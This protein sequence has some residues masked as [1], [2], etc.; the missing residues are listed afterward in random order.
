MGASLSMSFLR[1]TSERVKIAL[2]VL[3][4]VLVLRL[5][6]VL[7]IVLVP[8]VVLMVMPTTVPTAAIV[9]VTVATQ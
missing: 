9:T 7:G 6:L 1:V 2:L 5:V 8:V 3:G 4:V